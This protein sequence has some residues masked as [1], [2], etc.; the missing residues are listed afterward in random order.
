DWSSDVCSSDLVDG[1]SERSFIMPAIVDRD[2]VV[3]AVGTE[4]A[5]PILAREIKSRLESWLPAHFGRVAERAMKLR[6]R[7]AD[8]VT[9][10]V[11]RRRLWEALLQ[12]NW[13][14]SVLAGDDAAAD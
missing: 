13:R 2:P 14:A 3:V 11:A 6:H 10:P 12:G 5:A 8:A 4:G 9:D 1:P 7:L